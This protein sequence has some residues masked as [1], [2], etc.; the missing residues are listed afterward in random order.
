MSIAK[1][2]ASIDG[3]RRHHDQTCRYRGR[4]VE[5][6]VNPDD[7]TRLG[8]DDGEEI[9]GLTVV[10]DGKLALG[11]M[12]VYCDVELAGQGAPPATTEAISTTTIPAREAPLPA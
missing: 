10:H 5:V 8:L 4:A 7:A 9:C 3:A 12:R 2:M 1:A 6:H 11:R